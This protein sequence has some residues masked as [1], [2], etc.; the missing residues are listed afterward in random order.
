MI[1]K[2]FV[3][4]FR[5]IFSLVGFMTVLGGFTMMFPCF[6]DW[7][8]GNSASAG[9]FALSAA[10]TVA[11]GLIVWL[12]TDTKS[13]PLRTKEMF[14]TTSLIWISFVFFSA[15]PLYLLKLDISF[16]GALFEASSGL[17]TTGATVLTNLDNLS[18]GVLFWRSL[19]H[20]MGGIGIL[21]VAIM[22]LPTL[23]IGG[24]QLFNIE[25]SG[26]SN[27][28]SPTTIQNVSGVIGYF[29]F[30]TVV[31]FISLRLAGMDMFDAVNHAMSV[32][33]TGGFSTHDDSIAYFNSPIIE[34]ILAFFM[35]VGGFPL[36]LGILIFHR[37]FNQI[38]N[39]EQ[40]KVY[41]LFCFGVVFSLIFIRWYQ[42]SFDNNQ[43]SQ[44]LRTTIFDA[45]SIMTSTGFVIDDYE[46]WGAYSTVVFLLLMFVG[47]CTASTT[48]GIK[49]FRYTIL[50]KTI[51]S[52]L[53][54]A[55]RPY[56]VFIPRYGNKAVT[57]DVMSGVLVFFGLYAL[58]VA[59]GTLILSFYGLD[60]IT[61]LSG[62]VSML[63]NMGP[64]LGDV[65]GPDKTFAAL[66]EG[67]KAICAFLMIIGRLEFV[68]VFVLM[69]PFFW[70][71]N[72]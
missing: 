49:I 48:G 31:A 60:L 65:I 25:T 46:N 4:R 40:I 6:L 23:H 72:I 21:V 47:G 10:L 5:L 53:K 11:S 33:A 20:W 58:C 14:L 28:D 50:F 59:L 54:S 18:K 1:I 44:I 9:V 27:R 63:S 70:K 64:G 22:I 8:D 35:F 43:L 69:M 34:W 13:A 24:M 37:H 16:A 29:V 36:M 55:A 12:L 17:T 67:V 52:K 2:G 30:L 41:C 68:A 61:C 42:V 56:G 7:L 57:E 71:K 45:L 26:E 3:M 38:R 39:N 19:M 66:P 51:H 62:T 32:V 15:L